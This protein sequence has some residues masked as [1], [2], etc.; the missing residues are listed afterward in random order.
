LDVQRLPA[1][2][3]EGLTNYAEWLRARDSDPAVD[4]EL[5]RLDRWALEK[6]TQWYGDKA[7]TQPH[8][9]HV[10]AQARDDQPDCLPQLSKLA[11]DRRELAIVRA[12]ATLEL[13]RFPGRTSQ[14]TLI[15]LL[16]DSDP[17]VRAAAIG[18]AQGMLSTAE[19]VRYVLP[20]AEDPVRVVRFEAAR[21]TASIPDRALTSTQRNQRQRA[22]DEFIVGLKANSER[23]LSHLVLATLYEARGDD[24]AAEAAYRLAMH[25]EP[26]VSGP[27]DNL[28]ALLERRASGATPQ[29]SQ[30]RREEFELLRRDAALAPQ[31]ASL[32]YRFGLACYLQGELDDA[33]QAL[34]RACQT[35]PRRPEYLLALALLYEHQRR[36]A[37]AIRYTKTL[38]E[39][40]PGDPTYRQ[41][42][43]RI[44]ESADQPIVG[45]QP[46]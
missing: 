5:N 4:Q 14:R 6:V 19:Q 37:D 35:E 29:S 42:L 46:R 36:Y 25:V 15:A 17:Q 38:I 32:Q 7:S 30:L 8:F 40:R 11:L 13:A 22:I 27:R 26:A 1:E 45:P 10:L 20:L 41:V 43:A 44:E 2:S 34:L 31:V 23:A 33:E 18:S 24:E 21:V 9:A 28:A 39:L 12:T 3:A 16:N